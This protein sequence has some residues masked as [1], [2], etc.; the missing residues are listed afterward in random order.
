MEIRSLNELFIL[1]KSASNI[2]RKKK[3]N[4]QKMEKKFKKKINKFFLWSRQQ[5]AASVELKKFLF[6]SLG[7]FSFNEIFYG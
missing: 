5:P 2:F 7:Q 3:K 4:R 1:E 6:S